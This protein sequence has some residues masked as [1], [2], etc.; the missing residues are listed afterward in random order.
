MTKPCRYTFIVLQL[1]LVFTLSE[2][3]SIIVCIA[4]QGRGT[5]C[6]QEGNS[7]DCFAIC[8]K[9]E[10]L[11]VGNVP[12]EIPRKVWYFLRHRGQ[13]TCEVTGQR[14]RGNGLEVSCVSLC[15]KAM[16]YQKAQ[17]FKVM[18]VLVFL[19]L[20][21]LLVFFTGFLYF[22]RLAYIPKK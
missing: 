1:L 4:P 20:L 16:A 18:T 19:L 13:S 12:K 3:I 2:G 7:H 11:I 10:K 14:K 17:N 5:F 9:R 8:T 15:S 22:A 6:I 21:L